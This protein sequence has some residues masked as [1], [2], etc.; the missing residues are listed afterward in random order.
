TRRSLTSTRRLSSRP[1]RRWC[2]VSSGRSTR[3]SRGPATSSTTRV[4][5]VSSRTAA[6]STSRPETSTIPPH[7]S[8]M[9][10]RLPTAA[11]TRWRRPSPSIEK[12]GQPYDPPNYSIPPINSPVRIVT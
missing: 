8:P 6:A 9:S 5:V 11:A 7:G 2:S 4:W 10:A 3:T 12:R 1:R